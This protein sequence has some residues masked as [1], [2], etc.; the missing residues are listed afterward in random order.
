MNESKSIHCV[1]L[2]AGLLIAGT[3]ASG[4]SLGAWDF[5]G[6]DL[7]NLDPADQYALAAGTTANGIDQASL[8]LGNGVS[9]S[10]AS[11]QYGFR[12]AN[13]VA[14][15]SLAGAIA[16]GH[17]LEFTLSAETGS[18]LNLSSLEFNGQS[19][20][21]GA[22]SVAL[23]SSI[24]GFTESAAIAT[25]DNIAGV[26]GGF[27]TD[28]SGFGSPI[29]LSSGDFQNI[30]SVTFRLYG[31]NTTG[32]TGSTYFRNLSG[33]DLVINGTVNVPEPAT[34]GLLTGSLALLGLLARRRYR[35]T[36][37]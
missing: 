27:D 18:T 2:I 30:A 19:A 37:C 35:S 5:D 15:T 29:D 1:L 21:T 10:T 31:W 12:V 23:L 4:Q 25:L 3:C 16:G 11:G 20:A 7:D 28:G 36:D 8:R 14:Q 26:T 34:A 9:H 13:A 32:S 17:Y 33:N 24:G 6:I 22:D